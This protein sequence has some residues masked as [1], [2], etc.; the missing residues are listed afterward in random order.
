MLLQKYKGVPILWNTVYIETISSS[1]FWTPNVHILLHGEFSAM[2][3]TLNIVSKCCFFLIIKHSQTEMVLEIFS[4]GSWKVLEKSWIFFVSKRVETLVSVPYS[5][6]S[7]SLQGARK[8]WS[9]FCQYFINGCISL[10]QIEPAYATSGCRWNRY[11][12]F[13]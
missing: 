8:K 13:S 2:D 5:L 10:A 1:E 4:W 3:Y 12:S 11:F 9:V 6:Q 7:L